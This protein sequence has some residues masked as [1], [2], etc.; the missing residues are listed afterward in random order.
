M[1]CLVGGK[2]VGK[3][4]PKITCKDGLVK[5]TDE[6]PMA[7]LKTLGDHI[8]CRKKWI[9]YYIL[10]IFHGPKWRHGEKHGRSF[11]LFP[12]PL[13]QRWRLSWPC[14][15]GSRLSQSCWRA[16]VGGDGSCREVYYNW[17]VV[18]NIIYFF[19]PTWRKFT[20]WFDLYFSHWLKLRTR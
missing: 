18:S 19:T 1:L 5:K 2:G 7:N 10:L 20:I 4:L 16:M 14:S 15:T 8:L 9:I 3:R 17:V 11:W 12:R 13:E 6:K